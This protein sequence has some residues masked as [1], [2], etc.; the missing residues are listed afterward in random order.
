MH[1]ITALSIMTQWADCSQQGLTSEK[2]VADDDIPGET[3]R[4]STSILRVS[5]PLV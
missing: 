2:V 1:F 3:V 4:G 5:F